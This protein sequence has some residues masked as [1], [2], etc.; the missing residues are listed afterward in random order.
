MTFIPRNRDAGTPVLVAGAASLAAV[1]YNAAVDN[2][3]GYLTNA[4]AGTA[5]EVPFVENETITLSA[6]AGEMVQCL[7]TTGGVIFDATTDAA[8]AQ[9]DVGTVADLAGAASVNPDASA[10]DIFYIES[11]VGATADL[12]VRG[13]FQMGVPNA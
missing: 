5:V 9:T 11:I 2:G 7:R 3:S 10:N 12:L 4:A 8:P 6:T 1:K 13:H